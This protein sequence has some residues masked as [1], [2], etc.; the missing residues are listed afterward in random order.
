MKNTDNEAV[1]E[2]TR[3]IKDEVIENQTD[4]K[5]DETSDVTDK[6]AVENENDADVWQ[7]KYM[8][9]SAEF[10]NF[11]KRT[12]KEKLD[13]IANGGERVLKSVI[14]VADDFERALKSLTPETPEYTGVEMIYKKFIDSLKSNGVKVIE[15]VGQPLDIDFHEAV[16]KFP[17]ESPDK[18][19]I[20]IDIVQNGYMLNDKVLRFAKVVVG[21]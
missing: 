4:I 11:R 5:S 2:K 14:G 18:V 8:R 9:L 17:A 13:L 10:D 16:A 19:G 7:D 20:V 21:E 1:E 15:A 12:T 6:V 3:H